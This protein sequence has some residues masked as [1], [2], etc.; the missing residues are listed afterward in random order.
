MQ[1]L[2]FTLF[3][4]ISTL[5]SLK[6]ATPVRFKLAYNTTIS[7]YEVYMNS[8]TAYTGN[9]NRLISSGQVTI[10]VPT[11]TGAAQFQPTSIMGGTGG[12]AT[13]MSWSMTRANAPTEN[14]A[15]DYI[16]FE[17]SASA[18][19]S[20][21]FDIAANTDILL[22][23]FNNS[24]TCSNTPIA[25]LDNTND[26][27]IFPNSQSLQTANGITIYG[28]GGGD[29]YGSN[30][31][32]TVSCSIAA[33]VKYKLVFNNATSKYEVYMNSNTA[34]TGN[35]N[36]LISSAQATLVVPTG[37]GAAQFQPATIIGGTG[38]GATAMSWTMNRANAPTENP[39][40]DYI[41]FEYNASAN[42]SV[43]YDIAANTDILLFSFSNSGICSSSSIAL[44]NNTNDPFIFPN[45]QSLQ[46]VNGIT[47]FG[48]GS[49]DAYC[50]NLSGAV[51]CGVACA[52]NAGVL[53]R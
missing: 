28:N 36:R 2:S 49:G 6:A 20:V 33:C 38:G 16:L 42:P 39:T 53:S 43:S 10:V 1:K 23:S 40:K 11:G 25:L 26:P 19:P 30:L 27:F 14:T 34:F 45:S 46:T 35:P 4:F 5:L 31:S 12:G 15:K 21:S 32:S 48:N 44:I 47:I 51:N 22:F 37:T 41:L 29:A 8:T 18:N 17:Y 50:N 13:A 24:G 52:A 3:L 9:P 7:K